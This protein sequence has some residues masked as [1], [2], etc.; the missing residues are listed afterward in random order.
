MVRGVAVARGW[1]PVPQRD[2]AAVPYLLRFHYWPACYATQVFLQ[3]IK[4]INR[5]MLGGKSRLSIS[6]KNTKAENEKAGGSTPA[7]IKQT[8]PHMEEGNRGVQKHRCFRIWGRQKRQAHLST[9]SRQ[10]AITESLS[11]S[12]VGWGQDGAVI[13]ARAMEESS[14]GALPKNTQSH[15]APPPAGSIL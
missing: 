12:R 2:E 6:A 9:A 14:R 8:E 5:T 13:Q 1:A 11:I 3:H 4:Q 7:L 10:H 15:Q